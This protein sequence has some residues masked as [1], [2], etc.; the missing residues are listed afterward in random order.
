ML[1]LYLKYI[2]RK[3][4]LRTFNQ[5]LRVRSRGSQ[6]LRRTEQ[7]VECVRAEQMTELHGAGKVAGAKQ[8]GKR[9]PG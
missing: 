5:G 1:N 8:A 2:C 9:L 4:N 6:D 7:R 3:R